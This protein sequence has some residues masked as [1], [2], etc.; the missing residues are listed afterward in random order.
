[1]DALFGCEI[2]L[3]QSSS[4]EYR[5]THTW[6]V[7]EMLDNVET[8][9][10]ASH[11]YERQN[12]YPR[13][14]PRVLFPNASSVQL[15][16]VMSQGF[17]VLFLHHNPSRFVQIA[18]DDLQHVGTWPNGNIV[19]ITSDHPTERWSVPLPPGGNPP[20]PMRGL[21]KN[22]PQFGPLSKRITSP[23]EVL[24]TLRS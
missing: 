18:I 9:D 11:F 2:K 15:S 17:A 12:Q 1:L 5:T 3:F 7:F 19:C 13:S 23:P 4:E 21:L 8:L 10:F 20:G 22:L 6:Q 16:G 14:H 24:P